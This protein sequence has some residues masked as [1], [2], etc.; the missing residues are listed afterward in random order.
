MIEKGKGLIYGLIDPRYWDLIRYIGY[1]QC[2]H[3]VAKKLVTYS[4]DDAL[5]TR[6]I[7]HMNEC[8]KSE[9]H[10]KKICWL[11][12]LIKISSEP[13]PIILQNDI[14][15]L[16]D[17]ES[18]IIDVS[19]I[20]DI[21]NGWI[22]KYR[23]ICDIEGHPLTNTRSKGGGIAFTGCKHPF[24]GKTHKNKSK[25]KISKK[26][27][28]YF[29]THSVWNKNKTKKDDRRIALSE[30]TK[31]NISRGLIGRVFSESH[32]KSLSESK[33]GYKNPAKQLAVRNKI[34][35]TVH[36]NSLKK[37]IIDWA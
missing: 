25:K 9:R 24:T 3:V 21:E 31:Q 5:Q 22:E 6:F 32:L 37:I 34:A 1:T 30:R 11:R 7:A 13:I 29:K 28:V 12:K 19:K 26:L 16:F 20:Q 18:G 10:S 15:I 36:H 4:D 35:L 14:E 23:E 17:I 2:T 27:K 33:K 8:S